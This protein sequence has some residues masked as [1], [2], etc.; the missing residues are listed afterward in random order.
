MKGGDVKEGIRYY[1]ILYAAF[2]RSK[3]EYIANK[4]VDIE[5]DQS[6]EEAISKACT[7]LT[8]E[9]IKDLLAHPSIKPLDDLEGTM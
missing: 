9:N 6:F 3:I 5:K 4:E 7:K 8:P 2:L 1:K